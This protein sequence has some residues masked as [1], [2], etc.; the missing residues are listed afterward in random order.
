MSEAARK[1]V[2]AVA[3]FL[4]GGVVV[5]WLYDR[6]G[7]GLTVAA[8][9]ALIWQVRQLLAFD[10]ALRTGDFAE[11][12]IGEGL[13]QQYYS[14]FR[15]EH[16]KAAR[17]KKDYRRLLREIRNSTNAMP[18]GAVVLDAENEIVG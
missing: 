2:I 8:L 5:G 11:F 3:L 18:D 13:W 9:L 14:K 15:Y 7:T 16:D 12:R 4:A 1:F 6:P 17:Y 10:R